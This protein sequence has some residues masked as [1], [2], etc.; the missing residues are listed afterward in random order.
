MIEDARS[1]CESLAAIESE[2]V[3]KELT[4]DG[5]SLNYREQ[6][7]EVLSGLEPVVS[8]ADARPTKQSHDVYAKLSARADELLA[9]LTSVREGELAS[10]NSRLAGSAHPIVGA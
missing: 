3:Q 10:L 2:L 4:S 5:D 8:S 7:F 9:Q 6:L 1:V